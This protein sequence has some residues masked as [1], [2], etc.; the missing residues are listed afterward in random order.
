MLTIE[1]LRS[2][3]TNQ[4]TA[5]D[6]VVR[7]L[8]DRFLDQPARN[9]LEPEVMAGH[10]THGL[11][12]TTANEDFRTWL[13]EQIE[14]RRARVPR[15]RQSL[16]HYLPASLPPAL[17]RSARRSY[18]PS[19]DLVR[20]AVDHP[21]TRELVRNILQ[22][23][24]LEFATKLWTSKKIP[25]SRLRS[26]LMGMAKGV[27]G[28]VGTDGGLED[29]VHRFVDGTL[30]LA[31]DR[32]V[33]RVADPKNAREI[34]TQRALMVRAGLDLPVATL[35]QE[36]DKFPT[37]QVEEDVH[38]LIS[39]FVEWDRFEPT[40]AAVLADEIKLLG[41]ASIREVLAPSGLEAIWRPAIEA[42]LQR[43]AR[44]LLTSDVFLEWALQ[45]THPE[46]AQFKG[47]E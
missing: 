36:A 7:A 14:S 46:A 33:E 5:I 4:P 3:L 8:V 18:V 22:T 37:G 26:G 35:A 6:N 11:R 31:I 2:R 25:G 42:E 41:D 10:L 34:A 43:H 19:P 44:F 20:A 17:D 9:L 29:R 30:G 47:S 27:A 16:R 23:T 13:R 39:S 24:L 12:A 21:A 38:A 15:P 28:F 1:D 32:I 45:L 40:V